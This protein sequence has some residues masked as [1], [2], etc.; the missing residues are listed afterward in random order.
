[1]NANIL[2]SIALLWSTMKISTKP[3]LYA[4][5]DGK[6]DFQFSTITGLAKALDINPIELVE[7]S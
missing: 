6:R 1:M 5:C 2:L 7:K 3:T 4:I